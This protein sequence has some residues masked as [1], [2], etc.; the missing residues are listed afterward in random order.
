MQTKAT[1]ASGYRWRLIIIAAGCI[2]WSVRCVQDAVWVYPEQ[3]ERYE[4]F[5]A[6][7]TQNPDWQT[8]WYPHAE[9]KGWP[10]EEPPKREQYNILTQWVMLGL[11]GPIGLYCLAMV[12]VW[13]RKFIAIDEEAIYAQGGQRATWDQIIE[14]DANR[15]K[16]KGIAKISYKA[17]AGAG[18][19]V[20]D[21][22]KFDRE[23]AIA[24]FNALRE[25]VD[26]NVIIGYDDEEP[27]ESAD[28][29][30]DE[31]ADETP[32]ETADPP[33]AADEPNPAPGA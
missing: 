31:P 6:Y 27:S 14:I 25:N 24:I 28:E 26:D 4:Y 3:I 5:E 10:A 2:F 29:P 13:Q 11:T 8:S 30:A 21:D 20:L 32:N 7:K 17:N 9:A 22:W 18:T 23:P 33:P 19:I 1:I 16:S 12:V 15:W